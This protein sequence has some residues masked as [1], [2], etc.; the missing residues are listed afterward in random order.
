MALPWERQDDES[1]EAFE[2]FVTYRDGG[3]DRTVTAVSQ[4]LKKHRTLIGRWSSKYAWVDRVK[5]WE[6]YLDAQRRR[7][8]VSEQ[9]AVARRHL[10]LSQ[11]LS[12]K[13]AE[14]LNLM[15]KPI[16]CQNCGEFV[17]DVEGNPIPKIL[18]PRLIGQWLR[19]S[20]HTDR[21]SL[22]LSTDNVGKVLTEE[23][24]ESIVAN[25]VALFNGLI[26]Y[27][28]E[29]KRDEYRREIDEALPRLM[30]LRNM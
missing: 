6:G 20:V 13:V 1:L 9:E 21:L 8:M 5:A 16:V 18:P 26:C 17:T 22:G 25:V 30:G 2:A 10:Q 29:E 19:E 12:H 4:A 24:A 27:V 11:S 28:P 7:S 15:G 3:S 23:Q 14:S